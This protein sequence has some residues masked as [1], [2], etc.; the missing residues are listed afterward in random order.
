VEKAVGGGV[1]SALSNT[2]PSI[3]TEKWP[4]ETCYPFIEKDEHKAKKTSSKALVMTHAYSNVIMDKNVYTIEEVDQ[5]KAWAEQTEFPA[6]MQLDKAIYI[7]DVKETV[8][9]LVMQ[10]YVCYENPRLPGCL[11]LLERIKA[12]IEEEKRS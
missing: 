12:R 8:R 4:L 1:M 5:L 11:R 7:P 10:A 9:R 6:E 2:R 3:S